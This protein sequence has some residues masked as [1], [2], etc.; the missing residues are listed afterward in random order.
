MINMKSINNI[1]ET[2]KLKVKSKYIKKTAFIRKRMIKNKN[3]TIISN[4][5]WGGFVYQ[6]Y[7]LKYNTPTIGLF[8]M[9]DDYLKFIESLDYYLSIDN[10]D[11]IKPEESKWYNYLK[12]FSTFGTYPIAK[13]KDIE[14]FCLHYKSKEEFLKKW[15][16]RKKRVNYEKIIYKFSEMNLCDKSDIKK[17]LIFF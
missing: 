5:C 16:K 14:I 17:F 9:A 10:I 15:N 3:F 13:I 6:S 2:V 7:A 12:S 4:N 1:I 8:F 11:F